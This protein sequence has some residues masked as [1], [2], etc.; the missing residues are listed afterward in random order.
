MSL[1]NRWFGPKYNDDQLVF[2]A[3]TAVAEDP[4]IQA[5]S[6]VAINSARGVITLTG[7]VHR[8]TERDRIEGVVRSALSAT[9]T[10]FERIVNEIQVQ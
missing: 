6:E 1:L 4:L 3:Q 8:S 9:G 10:K 5:A 7:K 2:Q